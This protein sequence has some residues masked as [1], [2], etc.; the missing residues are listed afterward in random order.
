MARP[1]TRD[2]VHAAVLALAR[3]GRVGAITMEGIAAR[4]G[5]SKQTLYRSWPSTGAV[6]FDAL[7]ARSTDEE[8][9][10]VVPDTGDLRADLE[11]LCLGMV[12]ELT[13]PTHEPLLRAVTAEILTDDELATQLREQL[14]GV[15]LAAITERLQRA[16]IADAEDVTELL[17]GPVFHRWLLR[18]RPFTSAWVKTHVARTLRAASR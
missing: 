18:T 5:I 2:K 14:L 6:L 3:E 12:V 16:D 10:V 15:Q 17:V 9:A 13:D 1:R 7:L 4:A 11:T 8:G